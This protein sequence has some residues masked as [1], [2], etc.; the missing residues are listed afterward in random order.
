MCELETG[1]ETERA[2]GVNVVAD[3]HMLQARLNAPHPEL[4]GLKVQLKTME[5]SAHKATEVEAGLRTQLTEAEGSRQHL[6]AKISG[7]EDQAADAESLLL[8]HDDLKVQLEHAKNAATQQESEM[9]ECKQR[10]VEAES[11][12]AW[13]R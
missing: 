7:L 8:K 12:Q 5:Q 3:M 13:H 9:S 2:E 11:L 10:L 1:L 4:E 6:M